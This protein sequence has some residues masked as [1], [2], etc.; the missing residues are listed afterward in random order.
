MIYRSKI[1]GEK[2]DD[3]HKIKIASIDAGKV[4]VSLAEQLLANHSAAYT[5]RCFVDVDRN[6]VDRSIHGIPVL[7][8]SVDVFDR[9]KEAEVQEVVFAIPTLED[10]CKKNCTKSI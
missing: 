4:R 6:K 7:L 9:L 3:P 2:R 8:E 10:K 5:P 1:E